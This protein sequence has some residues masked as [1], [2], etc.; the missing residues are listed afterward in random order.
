MFSLGNIADCKEVQSI[1]NFGERQYS[2]ATAQIGECRMNNAIYRVLTLQNNARLL[3]FRQP[4][5]L[6]ERVKLRIL[7]ATIE[8]RFYG[9][10]IQSLFVIG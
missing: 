10:L 1:R 2:N 8:Y 6:N 5:S 3:L 9:Q 7:A 4:Q